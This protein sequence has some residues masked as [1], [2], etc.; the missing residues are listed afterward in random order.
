MTMIL[1]YGNGPQQ[2]NTLKLQLMKFSSWELTLG[3]ELPQ[4]GEPKLN[5]NVVS[6]FDGYSRIFSSGTA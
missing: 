6:L 2:G 3:S 1:S 5:R 4:Y